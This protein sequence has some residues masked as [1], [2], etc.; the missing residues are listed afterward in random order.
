M[1]HN[2]LY[3]ASEIASHAAGRWNSHLVSLRAVREAG[4]SRRKQQLG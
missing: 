4:K 1:G 2:P 3:S